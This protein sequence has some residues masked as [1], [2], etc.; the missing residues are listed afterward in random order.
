MYGAK[1]I[2]HT[3]SNSRCENS[4]SVFCIQ[5]VNIFVWLFWVVLAPCQKH[6]IL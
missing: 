6:R 4:R 2:R 3:I 5:C 1:N